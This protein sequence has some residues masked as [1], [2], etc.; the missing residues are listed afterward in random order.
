[1]T[2]RLGDISTRCARHGDAG[3]TLI[4]LIITIVIMGVITLPLGNLVI[5][6]FTNTA[7]TQARLAGSHD[8]QIAAAYFAQDMASMGVHSGGTA[9]TSLWVSP[10]SG[11]PPCGSTLAS[12][13]RVLVIASDDYSTVSGTFSG[14]AA[15]QVVNIAYVAKSIG[16]VTNPLYEL[17]RIRCV[18]SA[19]GGVDIT[20]MHNLAVVPATPQCGT[21]TCDSSTTYPAQVTINTVIKDTS[22]TGSTY[23]VA[24]SGKRRQT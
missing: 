5:S 11:A 13:T 12:G 21:V 3:F 2:K 8:A 10:F 18:G 9:G 17:H 20:V 24:L 23:P 16:S 22:S 7:A 15:P 1:V 19:T 14:T 6:Y 4:E